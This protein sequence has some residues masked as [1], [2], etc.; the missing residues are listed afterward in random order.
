MSWSTSVGPILKSAVREAIRDLALPPAFDNSEAVQQEVAAQFDAAKC[1][2][3]ELAKVTPGPNIS[4]TFSGHANA[5]G[6]HKRPGYANNCITVGVT[7]IL[8]EDLKYFTK[9]S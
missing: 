6:Y 5:C 2:A 7:Q 1:A 9:P 8:E 4:I 3:I